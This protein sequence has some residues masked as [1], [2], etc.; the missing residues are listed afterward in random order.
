MA[1]ITVLS[2]A[3]AG[4]VFFHQRPPGGR[5][6]SGYL[7]LRVWGDSHGGWYGTHHRSNVAGDTRTWVNFYG[8][9]P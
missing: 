5:R 4:F 3:G 7:D 8:F 9:W 6:H 2:L 1:V